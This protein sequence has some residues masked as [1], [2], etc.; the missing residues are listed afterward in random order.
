MASEASGIVPNRSLDSSMNTEITFENASENSVAVLWLNFVGDPV[1]YRQLLPGSSYKQPAYVNHAWVCVECDSGLFAL[2]K[3][4][5][6]D[7]LV[8]QAQPVHRAVITARETSLFQQCLAAVRM[9]LHE[10]QNVSLIEPLGR[11]DVQLPLSDNCIEQ[12]CDLDSTPPSQLVEKYV[13]N[14]KKQL[15]TVSL[16]DWN[17]VLMNQGTDFFDIG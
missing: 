10:V 2:M 4:N 12:L 11:N 13:E 7:V 1:W 3:V 8:L 17:H 9:Y 16:K 15:R 6:Q 5:K 14:L